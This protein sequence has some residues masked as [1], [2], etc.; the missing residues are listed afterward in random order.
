MQQQQHRY[1][2]PLDSHKIPV[3]M[4]SSNGAAQVV[5]ASASADRSN[6]GNAG[7]P[8]PSSS[9]HCHSSK[10]HKRELEK[11][12]SSIS[13]DSSVNSVSGATTNGGGG[14]NS[15]SKL[16]KIGRRLRDSCRNLRVKSG[17]ASSG[18]G[19]CNPEDYGTVKA[20]PD[21]NRSK[22]YVAMDFSGKV[23]R[24]CSEKDIKGFTSKDG[25]AYFRRKVL[26]KEV[27]DLLTESQSQIHLAEPWFHRGLSR[28]VAQKILATHNVD[29]AF[30]VRDSS[31]A[32]GFVISYVAKGRT[33]HAQ[34]LPDAGVNPSTGTRA[35]ST[36]F[37]SLDEGKTRF[38]DLM[39]MVE[40]YTLNQGALNARLTQYIVKKPPPESVSSMDEDSGRGISYDMASSGAAT[41]TIPEMEG[42]GGKGL[43]EDARSESPGSRRSYASSS[44]SSSGCEASMDSQT[45]AT[46]AEG[47]RNGDDAAEEGRGERAKKGS[48]SSNNG[49]F[50]GREADSNLAPGSFS[51]K[52][53]VEKSKTTQDANH[54]TTVAA[55][56]GGAS[57]EA[58][59][60]AAVEDAAMASEGDSDSMREFHQG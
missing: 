11:E 39:Q 58:A 34:V 53:H 40:F 32:G 47:K 3:G 48:S 52:G 4:T 38:Y 12:K 45:G 30:L 57:A 51:G 27:I 44:S 41:A 33:F 28:D 54:N 36:A 24:I 55:A 15:S 26:P 37:Y 16:S 49:S 25:Y 10:Q 23:G 50:S 43:Q 59:A 5:A 9:F 46:T 20:P 14:A 2:N 21:S 35:G 1:A 22:H 8:S 7:S 60:A 6:N 13:T 17:S 18:N 42:N 31:V 19:K 56:A 29:G